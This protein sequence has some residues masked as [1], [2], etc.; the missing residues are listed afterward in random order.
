MSRKKIFFTSDLHI[1]HANS[2]NFDKRPF[3]DI[4]DMHSGLIRRFNAVVGEK[5]VTYFLGDIGVCNQQV[6]KEV[7]NQLNGTKILI[8][9]NHDK[10]MNSSYSLGFDCVLGG[11][12]LFIAGEKVT[13]SHFPLLDTFREDVTGMKGAKDG[14]NWHGESKHRARA[15]VNDGQFHLS[16]HIHC[17]R[18][19]VE[20]LTKTGWKSCYDIDVNDQF[21]TKDTN[22]GVDEWNYADKLI[23][24]GFIGELQNIKSKFI[25]QPTTSE[26][27]FLTKDRNSSGYILSTHSDLPYVINK[28]P[29]VSNISDIGIPYSDDIIRLIIWVVTDG[30]F[31]GKQIRFHFS[32]ERKIKELSRL[33]VKLG[34]EF[35][36]NKQKTG[37]TKIGFNYSKRFAEDIMRLLNPNNKVLPS[38]FKQAN[39]EQ[40][41]LIA[42]TYA[43][44][45][46][47]YTNEKESNIQ[48]GSNKE[49]EI[50]ILQMLFFKNGIFSKKAS[51]K[52]KDNFTILYVN[53]DRD[54]TSVHKINNIKKE[55]YRGLVWCLEIKN[56]NFVIRHNGCISF[57]GNS[58]N[59]GKSTKILNRQFDVGV[60]ANNYGPVS[61]STIESWIAQTKRLELT[62][63]K[64]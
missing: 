5:G 53:K 28:Y 34:F 31:D 37:N 57:T 30:S 62:K 61:I 1:G 46:G 39:K 33:L 58:P 54:L 32:K 14:D 64:E 20:V 4:D 21:L 59:G 16:G 11:A 51:K 17:L 22:T 26:H 8:S 2:I 48:I 55:Y 42:D 29:V 25:S 41:L 7:L 36:S 63:I 40:A 24:S 56:S 52:G 47:C 45:D 9:G 43:I 44:T 38:L 19:D 15:V 23:T 27:K 49:V 12:F 60:V 3:K 50:D 13:L 10:G 18:D 35:S 6:A